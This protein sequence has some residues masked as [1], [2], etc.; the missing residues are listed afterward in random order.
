[1]SVVSFQISCLD[2]ITYTAQIAHAN[3]YSHAC[4]TL[5]A[6]GQIVRQPGNDTRKSRVYTT[7]SDEDAG[8][9]HLRIGRRDAP[10]ILSVTATSRDIIVL[11]LR[12]PLA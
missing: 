8:I 12:S 1:M 10:A 2:G 6:T 5:V 11:T 4:A 9:N 3:M 7:S